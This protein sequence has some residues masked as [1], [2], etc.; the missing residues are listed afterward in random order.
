MKKLIFALITS[1][2]AFSAQA[3]E[4]SFK[5]L[6]KIATSYVAVV[7]CMDSDVKIDPKNVTKFRDQAAGV[8]D[9]FIVLVPADITCAGGSGTGSMNII[10]LERAGNQDADMDPDYKYLNVN[11]HMSEPVAFA[12]S[13]RAITSIYQKNGQLFATGLEYGT[14]DSNCCPSLRT[15]YKVE[16]KKRSMELSKDESR[17]LY[18]WY[19]TKMKNY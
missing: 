8:D 3:K 6:A 19:F 1:S 11:I 5:A 4:P 15:L 18:S 2:I 14:N 12:N 17:I 10:L 16:L 7:G 13:P 9:A